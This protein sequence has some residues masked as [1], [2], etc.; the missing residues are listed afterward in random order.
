METKTWTARLAHSAGQT[1]T[2]E[3]EWDRG[4]DRGWRKTMQCV[5]SAAANQPEGRSA[6][7]ASLAG[8]QR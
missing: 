3:G 2:E 6:S 5:G 8:T 1:P 7:H 4:M